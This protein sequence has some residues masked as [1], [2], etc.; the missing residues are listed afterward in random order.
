MNPETPN[1]RPSRRQPKG[2]ARLI[3]IRGRVRAFSVL[4]ET[5]HIYEQPY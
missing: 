5:N 3:L 4:K 2:R 1:Q